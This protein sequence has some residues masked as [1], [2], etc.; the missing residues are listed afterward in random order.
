MSA[1]LSDIADTLDVLIVDDDEFIIDVVSAS[2]EQLGITKIRTA[3]NGYDAITVLEDVGAQCDLIICDINMPDMD[4]LSFMRHLASVAFEDAVLLMSGEDR[5]IL[6]AAEMLA[7]GLKIRLLGAIEKPIS[8]TVLED[9][10]TQLKPAS[11]RKRT[12][13]RQPMITTE[14]IRS[15][16]KNGEFDVFLQ[17]KVDAHSMNL[18]GAE[19]LARWHHPER[20]V[21]SPYFFIALAER[22]NLIKELT[23]ILVS[24]AFVYV[25]AWHAE[26]LK[27]R[28]AVNLSV[29]C[30]DDLDLPEF[31]VR[32]AERSG[33]NKDSIIL[34]IT[35]SRL[36]A[37]STNMIEVLT[38]LA[39]Q[40]FTLSIDD[41]G[42]GYSS[43]E[44]LMQ[45]PF[46]EMKI[47]RAFVH[48]AQN[49]YVARSILESSLVL[50]K[51]LDL[52]SVAEGV[53]DQSDLDVVREF[54]CHLVQ[55]Y[56]IS[57]PMPGDKFYKW[58][59]EWKP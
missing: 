9:K 51:K 31:L 16:M 2:L 41:F 44:K 28:I 18:V 21:L 24:R 40:G 12:T 13:S 37:N 1:I 59:T 38:R 30:L 11:S 58:A 53:E 42:T 52:S 46:G 20:G 14:N 47:D 45:Y 54:G 56:F 8:L 23:Y 4:G 33:V 10:L 39:L 43:M 3:T 29:D 17:P 35:E 57:K 32:E 34:E 36:M 26:G 50:A 49:D 22:E 27:L 15:G 5:R 25:G 55:G 7:Q 6:K 48:G 19:A